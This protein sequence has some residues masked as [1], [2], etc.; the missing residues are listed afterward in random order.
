M[1][2]NRPITGKTNPDANPDEVSAVEQSESEVQAGS[3][4]EAADV[5]QPNESA[6][7]ETASG[8]NTDEGGVSK[9]KSRLFK[10][11]SKLKN[12]LHDETTEPSAD[13]DGDSSV[14]SQSEAEPVQSASESVQ[15]TSAPVES[16]DDVQSEAP[17]AKS[18][19]FKVPNKLRDKL[20]HS[21]NSS[22]AAEVRP[23]ESE[24]ESKVEEKKSEQP[25]VKESVPETKS[26][27][28][29]DLPAVVAAG[30]APAG[31]RVFNPEQA[32]KTRLL[33]YSEG[34]Y[35]RLLERWSWDMGLWT[36]MNLS[37]KLKDLQFVDER[38]APR[39][40]WVAMLTEVDRNSVIAA[41]AQG[42]IFF[43]FFER[44]LCGVGSRKPRV[45]R[46]GD[47]EM[48]VGRELAERW[49]SS[50]GQVLG[51]GSV[52]NCRF[53]SQDELLAGKPFGLPAVRLPLELT[54]GEEAFE[55]A[56]ITPVALLETSLKVDKTAEESLKKTRMKRLT[57][58][59]VQISAILG[60]IR[61]SLAELNELNEGDCLILDQNPED[62]I[63]MEL[64]KKAVFIA[65]PGR[66]GSHL[67]AEIIE[68]L[69][70]N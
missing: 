43:W 48:S 62:P 29:L 49:L 28:E 19:M 18:R 33:N 8:S 55:L 65:R 25:P 39:K 26:A 54:I 4:Q 64:N 13:A 37:V 24:T 3:S 57:D 53:A 52:K 32:E 59:V 56:F 40:N 44:M 2:F 36:G 58:G 47:I 23:P 10:V 15:Q 50:F 16:S 51:F 35:Q 5:S 70:L 1:K 21:G 17:K 7:A 60:S 61:L 30:S 69:D 45:G 9:P 11:P 31:I 14:S 22:S 34:L 66:R 46:L 63:S 41:E 68:V 12:K 42:E 38:P 6:N 20:N 67:A 27:V